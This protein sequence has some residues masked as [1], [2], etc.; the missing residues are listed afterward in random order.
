MY[1]NAQRHNWHL[2]ENQTGISAC[3]CSIRLI[4]EGFRGRKYR[5]KHNVRIKLCPRGA[6][7]CARPLF[8]FCDLDINPMTLKLESGLDILKVYLHTE[9]EVARLRHSKL[10]TVGILCLVD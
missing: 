6:H 3:S 9:N 5:K 8:R 7:T 4:T 10:L 2:Q 1:Y